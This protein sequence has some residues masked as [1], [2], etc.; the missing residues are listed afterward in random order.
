M[1][2]HHIQDLQLA[3]IITNQNYIYKDIKNILK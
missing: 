2:P 3:M 1:I